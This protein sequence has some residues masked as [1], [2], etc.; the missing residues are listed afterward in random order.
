MMAMSYLQSKNVRV[1][2]LRTSMRLE[3]AMWSAL[4]TIARWENSTVEEQVNNAVLH[5]KNGQTQT[6][7]VR[8]YIIEY[9]ANIIFEETKIIVRRE[10]IG[11]QIENA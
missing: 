5:A 2:G 4:G 6:S 9:F 8:V 11:R 1:Q 3:P 10:N 7:A